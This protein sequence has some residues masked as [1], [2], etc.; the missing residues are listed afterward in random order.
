MRR[1]PVSP[2]RV[3]VTAGWPADPQRARR[4]VATLIADGLA[5]VDHDG[6][7]YGSLD[8]SLD[9][10]VDVFITSSLTECTREGP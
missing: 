4:V 6:A 8:G 10:F 5:V 2:A 3:A 7:R 9:D 1:G